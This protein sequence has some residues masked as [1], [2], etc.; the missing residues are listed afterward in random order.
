MKGRSASLRRESAP[1]SASSSRGLKQRGVRLTRRSQ[2]Y[3]LPAHPAANPNLSR[4]V[5]DGDIPD[6][7]AGLHDP[8]ADEFL[9]RG[10][11]DPAAA[12]LA[13]LKSASKSLA[14]IVPTYM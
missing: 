14:S 5:L 13:K 6:A 11:A 3:G 10:V 12:V 1:K 4:I 7:H 2:V 9:H 8:P